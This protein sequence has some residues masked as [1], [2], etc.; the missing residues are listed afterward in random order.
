MHI[1]SERIYNSMLAEHAHVWCVPVNNGDE[2]AL[3]IKSITP[4]LKALITGC[5][6]QLLFGK[7]DNYLCTGA[8]IYDMPD[9]PLLISESQIVSE[10]HAALVQSMKQAQAF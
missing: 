2:T 3:L 9:A 1:P 10:E 4:S 6:I 5:Q 7:K 8:R